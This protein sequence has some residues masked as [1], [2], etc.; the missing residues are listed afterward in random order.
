MPR[1]PQLVDELPFGFGWIAPEPRF[2]QRCAHAL[3]VGGKVWVVD[4][5][6]GDGVVD[7]IRALGEPAGI[8]V[9]HGRHDRDSAALAAELAVPLHRVPALPPEPFELVDLGRG[10]ASLWLAE[11][12]TLVVAEA[13]GTVQYMRAPGERLG[14]HPFRRLTPPRA[15][16][17]YEPEHVLVG[18]GEGLHGPDAAAALQDVLRHGPQRTL[19]WLWS[20]FKAHGLGGRRG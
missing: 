9:L 2:M 13:L 7:A 1:E 8:L 19:S 15:L 20:G 6:A 10:E 14:L 5:V 17:R 4:P 3:A 16:A 11:E 12:R 18:H